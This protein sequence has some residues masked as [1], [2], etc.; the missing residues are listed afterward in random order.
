MKLNRMVSPADLL[1]QYSKVYH[2]KIRTR[3]LISEVP[4]KVR[5]LEGKP[6]LGYIPY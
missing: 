5:D 2:I 3:T 6:G 4:K 1:L